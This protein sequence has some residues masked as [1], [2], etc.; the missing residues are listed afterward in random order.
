MKFSEPELAA[1]ASG[2]V[3][4]GI[5]FR[6]DVAPDPVRLWL[7]FG[8]IAPGADVLDPGGAL[9][10]GL[11][12]LRDVPAFK[13]LLNGTAERVEFT[14]SGVSGGL[15]EIASGD[16]S[17]AIKGCAA[18][19]GFGLFGNSW[20]ALLGGV[21][22]CAYYAADYLQIAQSESEGGFVRSIALSCGTR[23][24]GRRRPSYGYF[25][26]QDQQARFPGDLFCSLAKNYAHG[27]N[28]T[29]PV[30]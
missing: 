26:D 4:I 14:L 20:S 10:R 3:R 11:G 27:Y 13:Q 6:L 30:F 24:T 17:E 7:G 8:N 15:L 21:H 18:T 28:K 2:V 23:F 29:F 22:W 5:F 12:E 9:Y 19:L 16:D 25:S 1:L